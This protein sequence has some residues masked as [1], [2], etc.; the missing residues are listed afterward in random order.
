MYEQ[1]SGETVTDNL[2]IGCVVAGLENST[3]KE[4]LVVAGAK[5]KTWA[6]FMK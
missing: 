1:Q 4:H 6:E 5:A 2:K 3:L